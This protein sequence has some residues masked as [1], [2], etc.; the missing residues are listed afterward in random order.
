MIDVCEMKY[1]QSEFVLT[2]E[3]DEHLRERNNTFVHLSK[4]K[5]AIHNILVTTYGLKPNAYSDRF[6]ATVT[7]DDLF[8]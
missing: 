8:G 2:R 7:M 4:T 1:C 6:Y 3:Y 5:D